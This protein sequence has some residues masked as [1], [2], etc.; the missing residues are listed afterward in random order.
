MNVELFLARRIA[1]GGQNSFSKI[2]IRIAAAAIVLSVSVMIISTALIKGFKEEIS[3]KVFGFWGHIHIASSG[4]GSSLLDQPAMELNDKL[5]FSIDT[6]SKAEFYLN[7]EE[8]NGLGQQR[9]TNGGVKNV[10][11]YALIPGII[12]AKEDIEGI[13][14]KG[15]GQDFDWDFMGQ[16]LIEGEQMTFEDTVISNEMIISQ[17]TAKRLKL[18][19][20]D[21]LIMHFI[22][23]G[24]QLRRKFTISSIYKT[25]LEEYDRQFAIIDIRQVQQLMNWE[26]NEVSG[27]E[28]FVDDVRDSEAIAEHLYF[29]VL[30]RALYAEPIRQKIPEIFEWLDLQDTNEGVILTLMV[31]VAIINMTTSLM[32]LILERTN[33]IGVLKALGTTNWK[34]QKIFLYQAGYIVLMGLLFGNVLGLGLCWLQDT[35]EFIKLSEENYYLAVAPVQIDWFMVFLIN[36]GTLLVTLTFLLLPTLLVAQVDPVKAIR[37][38]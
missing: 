2:I 24:E 22:Q 27:L 17:Q 20:G 21:D 32:I 3:S 25:G 30:P 14:L 18:G 10:Q 12:Q 15:I 9:Y 26:K 37:F 28:V 8:L 23:R 36:I 19:L 33:M 31:I 29:E 11:A 16:Y 38:K 5:I 7:P 1:F 35:F 4:I 13:I 6:L 34:I